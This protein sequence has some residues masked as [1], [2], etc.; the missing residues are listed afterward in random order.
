MLCQMPMAI[1]L[2]C[3][4][5][6]SFS[7][8]PNGVPDVRKP[9]NE[10]EEL[11]VMFRT[12]LNNHHLLFGAEMDGVKSTTGINNCSELA[13]AEFIELKTSRQIETARQNHTFRR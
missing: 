6:N 13:K 3:I 10:L 8:K 1:L 12:K 9:V 2:H 5:L 4:Y 11:C 7:D